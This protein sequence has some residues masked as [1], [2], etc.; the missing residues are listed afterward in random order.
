MDKAK[1]Q[2]KISEILRAK[3]VANQA[4]L[5][6]EL[7]KRGIECTQASVSRDLADLGVVKVE[8][9]YRT[10]Q[11]EAGQSALVDRLTVDKCGDHL[12]V[13]R[14][15]P[16]HAMTAALYIDRAKITGIVGTIAG[17]DTIFIAV[18]SLQDQNAV[19]K[20]IFA[21]FKQA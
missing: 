18:R 10:P 13:V 15:G 12:I 17:D 14:T 8:G 4:E 21:V 2:Q 19:I 7:E 5:V 1:R 16:A 9:A 20:R 3:R 6:A 11:L